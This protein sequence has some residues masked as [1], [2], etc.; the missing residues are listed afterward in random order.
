MPG[1]LSL[2]K[3]GGP[4]FPSLSHS[5]RP[6]SIVALSAL[7][8]LLAACAPKAT[9]AG[10]TGTSPADYDLLITGGKIVDGSGNP[11][12]YGDVAVR[13]DRIVRIAPPGRL[14]RSNARRVVDAAGL[15]VAPGFIDIQGQSV[16]QFTVG[17][18][19][20]V[21]K[22]T[23]GI[24]TEIMGEGSSPAPANAATIAYAG[25]ESPL[26]AAMATFQG[27]H[28]FDAWLRTMER[29]G[30]SENVGSFLGAET[31]RVYAKGLAQ[32]APTPA[33]LDIMRA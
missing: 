10:A 30:A 12:F 23:Q 3:S 29:H 15:V 32:G 4:A 31:V 17:D 25:A 13:A 20:V 26:A 8:F 28:G 5:T 22:V 14:P 9:V 24:T 16:A 19:R 2:R 21:S 1:R 33:E 11:W 6:T 27:T 7:G 18:G